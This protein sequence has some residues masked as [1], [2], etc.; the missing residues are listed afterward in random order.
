MV[1]IRLAEVR[2]VVADGVAHA[3]ERPGELGATKV[4]VRGP[5]VGGVSE[6]ACEQLA[7][8]QRAQKIV[9]AHGFSLM[10]FP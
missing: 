9:V 7:V 3:R 2:R 10:A 6:F 8:L 4:Q 5:H 1:S